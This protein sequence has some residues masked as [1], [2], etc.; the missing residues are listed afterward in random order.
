MRW[1]HLPDSEDVHGLWPSEATLRW[2]RGRG[3][4]QLWWDVALTMPRLVVLRVMVVMVLVWGRDLSIV[5]QWGGLC[6]L[7]TAGGVQ[8][9]Q[10]G[11]HIIHQGLKINVI[12]WRRETERN[13]TL[14]DAHGNAQK[15]K[16]P[17]RKSSVAKCLITQKTYV[18][19]GLILCKY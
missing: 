18:S 11:V 17:Q 10:R 19:K 13:V 5:Q 14:T 2:D 16:T 9:L 7:T 15:M 3:G 4:G 12:L 6:L 1:E 8:A